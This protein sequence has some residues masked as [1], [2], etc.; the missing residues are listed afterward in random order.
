MTHTL[1]DDRIA[2]N[3]VTHAYSLSKLGMGV[4]AIFSFYQA[5]LHLHARIVDWSF[6]FQPLC[7]Y[8]MIFPFCNWMRSDYGDCI[9]KRFQNISIVLGNRF[10]HCT[11]YNSA[12]GCMTV[13]LS[14][15]C[16]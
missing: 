16:Y 14:R 13:S 7:V 9:P 1:I 11:D 12:R 2:I 10:N 8:D 15:N 6:V 5:S 3:R 4:C